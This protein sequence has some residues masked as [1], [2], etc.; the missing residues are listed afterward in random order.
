[1][2][3]LTLYTYDRKNWDAISDTIKLE[4][5]KVLTAQ[6]MSYVAVIRNT[7]KKDGEEIKIQP[8]K[9]EYY[10]ISLLISGDNERVDVWSGH[11]ITALQLAEEDHNKNRKFIV[12]KKYASDILSALFYFFSDSA[13][14]EKF[15]KLDDTTVTNIVDCADETIVGLGIYL[16]AN[17]FGNPK[18][19]TRLIQELKRFRLF[20]K[21][22]ER[23]VFSAFVCGP[24]GIG[25]TLTATLLHDFLAPNERYIKIN[26]GNYSDHNALS[27]LIGSPRGY[28]GSSKG[29]LSSK[30]AESKSTVILIDEF[31]K[32]SQEVHNFFLELLA[33]G[34]FTDSQGREYDLNKYI[35]I[36]TS[37]IDENEFNRKIPPEL[38]SR[39]D[40][41]Y[42]MVLLSKEEKT[43]YIQYKTNY[44]VEQVKEMMGV[45]LESD[46]II[47]NMG[48]KVMNLDNIRFITRAIEQYIAAAVE[49]KQ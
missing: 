14:L 36:F 43:A 8:F 34:K 17:L 2:A 33:D 30:I 22:G 5:I 13:P 47:A 10:D 1:M 18:F 41:V 12:D 27:S 35:I 29:E 9:H 37:N 21:L 20:N 16:Q 11:L 31:E 49:E 7:P 4:N 39:F 38:R 19:K 45:S 32:A 24:S 48:S 23:K 15:L 6:E 44:Y 26:L 42:K 40:L 28:V 3:G 25:K 46:S